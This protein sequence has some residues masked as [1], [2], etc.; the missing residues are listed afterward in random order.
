[1]LRKATLPLILLCSLTVT[2]ASATPALAQSKKG[3][4][5]VLLF[6]FVTMDPKAAGDSA[7]GNFTFNYGAFF[8]DHA[9]IGGGPSINVSKGLN[10]GVDS[11]MGV[12][13][14][15]RQHFGKAKTQPYIGG[16]VFVQ[17]VE[18][19]D[20]TYLDGI[21]GVKNYL[22]EHAAVD[23]KLAYGTSATTPTFGERQQLLVFSV[24]L[25][26]LF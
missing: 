9:E 21:F 14:F 1:M 18:N 20:S 15:L 6:G 2:L 7:S 3:D 19:S 16:E 13:F 4:S 8:T 26:V 23:F 5:E 22:S 25:T 10:G 11:T 12:N 17:D 24:G